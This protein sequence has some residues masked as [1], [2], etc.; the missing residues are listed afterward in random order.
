MH[1]WY[2]PGCICV[3]AS[4]EGSGDNMPKHRAHQIFN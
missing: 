3:C 4:S 2:L 1:I